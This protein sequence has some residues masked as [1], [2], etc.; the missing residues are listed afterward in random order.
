MLY[1]VITLSGICY[2]CQFKDT[3]EMGA[4]A[5]IRNIIFDL[6]GVIID[7][8]IPLAQEALTRLGIPASFTDYSCELSNDLF[9]RYETGRLTRIT[10]YNVCY[11][12]LLR[13]AKSF[14]GSVSVSG[15]L[16]SPAASLLTAISGRCLPW[17]LLKYNRSFQGIGVGIGT[18]PPPFIH[19]T[20]SVITSYSIHYTKLYDWLLKRNVRRMQ[21]SWHSAHN[22]KCCVIS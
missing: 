5:P 6:G 21:R 4:S 19:Q 16:I 17:A 11:T 22:Y 10:S 14:P 1:E 8:D 2:I 13:Q 9:L 15:Y 20:S 12:K 7:L 3:K 18:S